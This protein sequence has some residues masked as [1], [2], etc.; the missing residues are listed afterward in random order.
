MLEAKAA[1]L[2]LA[3]VTNASRGSLEPFLEYGLGEELRRA[4][5]FI[6][7][8]EE[9]ARKKPAPDLYHMAL[10]KVGVRP[11]QCVALED[12][13]M[14]LLAARRAGIPTLI[15]V[16]DDT[17]HHVFE[18]AML[19]IDS[20]GEPDACFRV[21]QGEAGSHCCVTVG[22]LEELLAQSGASDEEE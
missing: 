14:G 7:S 22:L 13:S 2:Q 19:V 12:S 18:E 17:R 10:L 5:D 3:I 9:V 15:T 4:V 8:G 6:V 16:N 21:L 11:S 1:G 20:L